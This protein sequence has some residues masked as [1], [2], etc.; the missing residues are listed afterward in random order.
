MGFLISKI[1]NYRKYNTFA[2]Q[3][4]QIYNTLFDLRYK[5]TFIFP[6]IFICVFKKTQRPIF[7]VRSV[8]FFRYAH[9][10]KFKFANITKKP[11]T[12]LIM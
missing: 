12:K 10:L 1:N 9:W 7:I 4:L 8:Y 6:F 3:E 11:H 2:M 5:S